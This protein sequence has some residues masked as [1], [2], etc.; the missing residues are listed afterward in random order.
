MGSTDLTL[1]SSFARRFLAWMK[2]RFPPARTVLF[3]V[4]YLAALLYGRAVAGGDADRIVLRPVDLLG[5]VGAWFF[6]FM[7]RVID[8]HKDYEQDCVDHP[9][10]V[11]QRGLVTLDHLK[12]AG[13]IGGVA[14]L[15]AVVVLDGLPG[16]I[17]YVWLAV[18]GWTVLIAFEFFCGGWLGRRLVLYAALHL[19]VMPIGVLWMAQIGAGE[20]WLPPTALF[21]GALA[22]LFG[23][24]FEMAR[25]TL[26]PEEEREGVASYSQVMGP[27]AAAAAVAVLLVG[28][29]AA[30]MVVLRTVVGTGCPCYWYG[31]VVGALSLQLVGPLGFVAAPSAKRRKLNQVAVSLAMILAY[32]II[33][34]AVIVSRGVSLVI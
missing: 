1:E 32:L 34:T 6:F 31:L 14:Q 28:A 4:I 22:Y 12:V 16:P 33:G 5:F 17:T 10:R 27:R 30:Q 23:A 11:L 21:F 7:L 25:K 8:E 13:A 3:L 9:E 26:G 20:R 15:A 2:E 18:G 29:A 24:S 19:V